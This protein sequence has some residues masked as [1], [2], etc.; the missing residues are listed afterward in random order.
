MRFRSFLT[1]AVACSALVTLAYQPAAASGRRAPAG[2][3]E[4]RV[5]HHHVYFPHHRYGYGDADPYAYRYVRPRYYP[6]YNSGYWRPAHLVRKPRPH[7]ELPRYYEAWGYP[8]RNV[9]CCADYWRHHRR[10]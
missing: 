4:T 9:G 8:N 10:Y 3:G 7:Y 1:L 5:A 2:D 6:Y